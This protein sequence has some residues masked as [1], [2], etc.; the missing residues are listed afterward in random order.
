[1]YKGLTS[2]KLCAEKNEVRADSPARGGGRSAV[3]TS[4]AKNC[5]C[6]ANGPICCGGPSAVQKCRRPT[7][8]VPLVENLV[9]GGLFGLKRQ[10][11]PVA[12]PVTKTSVIVSILTPGSV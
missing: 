12:A 10:S 4:E 1:M 3:K 7:L 6:E 5:K 8:V 2:V 11:S 9:R